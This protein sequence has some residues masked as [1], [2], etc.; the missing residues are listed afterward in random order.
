MSQHDMD[1]TKSDANTGITMRTEINAALKAL[2]SNSNG[3]S[4]PSTPYAF[5][6]WIDTGSSPA[7]AKMRNAN[8]DA[9]VRFG[10]IDATTK[11]L[12][13]DDAT[14]AVHGVP[15]GC[16]QSFAGSTAPTGWLLCYGQAVSRTTYADLFAVISTTFGVGDGSTT[17]NLPDLRGRTPIGLDNMGG[18]SADR[19]TDAQADS[20]GG[21]SGAEDHTLTESEIPTHT[22]GLN[23]VLQNTG[24]GTNRAGVSPTGYQDITGAAGGGGAHNNMQ[25]YMALNFIIKH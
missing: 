16:V 14:N 15:V 13:M 11:Q 20:L 2:A 1:I 24:A 23:S 5:Q 22:H 7:I 18:S 19:V 10:Y 9:W 21:A 12:I 25:P 4:A 3:A 6:V 8:N 17:F